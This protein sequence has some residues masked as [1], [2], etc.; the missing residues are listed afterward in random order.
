VREA[1]AQRILKEG[2]N[3]LADSMLPR[4]LASQTFQQQPDLAEELRQ[5]ICRA[6]PQGAAAATLGMAQRRD[7]QPV[8]PEITCPTLV[9]V[10]AEDVISPPAEMRS[11]AEAIPNA[12]FV[13]IAEAGHLAPLEKPGIVADAFLDFLRREAIRTKSD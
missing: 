10:G 2:T 7:M 5:Q 13:E 4:L 9:L 12:Q 1:T 6:N 8:L 3:F 11:I